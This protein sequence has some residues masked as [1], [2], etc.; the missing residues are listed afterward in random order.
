MAEEQEN[1]EE[2]NETTSSG[3]GNAMGTAVKAAAA[4]A[5]TGAAAVAVKKA[6]GVVMDEASD[7]AVRAAL[8]DFEDAVAPH[9]AGLYANFVEEPADASAF[10]APAA[11]ERLRAVKTL[12]DPADLF[13][14]NHHVP[15]ARV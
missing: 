6:L 4:A 8:A 11:W 1:T 5:A 2:N 12:Y 9:R 13:A 15:P 14:G 10:F 7:T 3:G